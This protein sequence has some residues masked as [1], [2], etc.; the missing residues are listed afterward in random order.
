MNVKTSTTSNQRKNIIVNLIEEQSV[1]SHS[2]LIKLLAKEGIRVTQATVS[3]DLEDL[4]AVRVRNAQGLMEYSLPKAAIFS[5]GDTQSLILSAT[6]SAN[7]AVIKTP[8][9]GAQL[10]ASAID[11]TELHGFASGA[12][13]PIAGDDT[14][15]VISQSPTGGNR[16]AKAILD[17]RN[18]TKN[19]KDLKM[20]T[21]M[22]KK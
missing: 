10:L 20:K 21:R 18:S 9:G 14:V 1:E 16:L 15:I 8:P 6:G 3:R 2:H 19:Q 17:F 22:G 5:G 4:G 13:G 11:R 12:I 7:L